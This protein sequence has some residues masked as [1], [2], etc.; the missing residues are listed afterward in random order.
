MIIVKSWPARKNRNYNPFQY[1]LSESL[2]SH[3]MRVEEFV[4]LRELWQKADVWHWHWPDG[5]FSGSLGQVLAHYLVLRML[6][7][8]AR[9]RSIPI[10]WTVHNIRGHESTTPNLEARFMRKFSK[11]VSGVHYLSKYSKSRA[12]KEYP[13]LV[14]IPNIVTVHGH[15]RGVMKKQDRARSRVYFNIPEEIF[16]FGFVGSI[17]PYKGITELYDAFFSIQQY[18]ASP[19][20]LL[21]AG[22]VNPLLRNW[23][24]GISEKWVYTKFGLLTDQEVE[25]A[26]GAIDVLILPYREIL[27]S[28]TALLGLS[29]DVPVALPRGDLARELQDE[30]GVQNVLLLDQP[31][32]PAGLAEVRKTVSSRSGQDHINLEAFSWEG[33]ASGVR[34]LYARVA[35]GNGE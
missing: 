4:P 27:N 26:L 21:L 25:F 11:S 20:G 13:A 6:L 28:G 9:V 30:I 5:N 31:L 32:T 15:Y 24:S 29:L 1:L 12:E 19:S 7:I 35:R 14:E 22:N 10:V 3:D 8:S 34:K 23:V 17:S 18:E 33:V 2:E 16:C